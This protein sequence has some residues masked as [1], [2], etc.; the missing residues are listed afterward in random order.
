MFS[1]L[2]NHIRCALKYVNSTFLFKGGNHIKKYHHDPR[3]QK[4]PVTKVTFETLLQNV[5]VK[6][7]KWVK[8]GP[9]L[10]LAYFD[11]SFIQ[12]E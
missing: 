11:Q 8:Y 6:R 7:S 12:Q 1:R 5:K 3:C 10:P 9:I 4:H 2:A